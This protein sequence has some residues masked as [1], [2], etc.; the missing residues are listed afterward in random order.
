ME[1]NGLGEAPQ[2]RRPDHGEAAKRQRAAGLTSSSVFD[3]AAALGDLHQPD[4]NAADDRCRHPIH[5]RAR[6][7]R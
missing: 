6:V 3:L 7:A 5:F 2:C 1:L 4:Q